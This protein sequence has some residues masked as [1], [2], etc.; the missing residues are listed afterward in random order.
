MLFGVVNVLHHVAPGVDSPVVAQN[1]SRGLAL[2]AHLLLLFVLAKTFPGAPWLA[3][4]PSI[5]WL[6]VGTKVLPVATIGWVNA[7]E[8]RSRLHRSRVHWATATSDKELPLPLYS[9]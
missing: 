3:T 2:L 8:L 9:G 6:A 5:P 1:T 4:V 7:F